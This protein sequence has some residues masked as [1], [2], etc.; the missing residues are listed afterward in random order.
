MK[1]LKFYDLKR[2]KSFTTDKY[3]LTSKRTK[4]GMRY[5]AVTKAPSNV[6]SWRIVGKDFYRKH[7]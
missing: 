7:K 2:R 3:R 5:F 1:R 4:K 6:E